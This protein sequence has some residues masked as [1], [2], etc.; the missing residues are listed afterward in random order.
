MR[1]DVR[2]QTNR[3]A[4]ATKSTNFKETMTTELTGFIQSKARALTMA[5]IDRLIVDLPV[6]RK[7]F[8][9]ISTQLSML[10]S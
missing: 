7:R 5:D 4:M 2:D 6:L 8:S 1:I 3:E 10:L 9:K